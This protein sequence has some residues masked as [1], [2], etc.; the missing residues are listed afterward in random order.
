MECFNLQEAA[1][2]HL[3]TFQIG[4]NYNTRDLKQ[5]T[6]NKQTN[7]GS[8]LKSRYYNTLA[9][10]PSYIPRTCAGWLTS[11]CNSSSWRADALFCAVLAL[12]HMCTQPPQHIH[13]YITLKI[14]KTER[15]K[16]FKYTIKKQTRDKINGRLNIAEENMSNF[17]NVTEI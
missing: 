5:Q 4:D 8:E 9:V 11:A 15:Y 13:M 2:K 17:K 6:K 12:A 14:L 16:V 7:R 10:D 1:T 3:Q